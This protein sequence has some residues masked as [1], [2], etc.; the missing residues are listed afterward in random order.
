MPRKIRELKADLRRAGFDFRRAKGSHT[1]WTH[2]SLPGVSVTI[3]G[4]DG[5][6]ARPYQE[7]DVRSALARLEDAKG[8]RQ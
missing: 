6:D 3:S 5:D 8:Q 1:S 4:N 7:R 2:P